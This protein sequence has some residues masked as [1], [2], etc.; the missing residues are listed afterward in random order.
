M[1]IEYLEKLKK[2]HPA[3][4]LL[5]ADHAPLIISFLYSK[6]IKP[7]RRAIPWSELMSYLDDYLYPLRETY[8]E[9][10]Y[11][12]SAREY[13][14]D[15]SSD[16]K[17][18]FISKRYTGG[19]DPECDLTPATEKA[20]EWL[21]G[22]EQK[23]FIGT[24][25]RLLSMFQLLQEIVSK[26]EQ[27]PQRRILEL[28]RQKQSI[29]KEIHQV[30]NGSFSSLDETQIKERFYQL[31]ETARKLLAD[32]RQVEENFRA[33]DTETRERIATSEKTK[34]DLLDE[35]FSEQDFI[36]GSDQGKSFLA[37]W[38]FLMSPARQTELENL[39]DTVF[40]LQAIQALEPD[41]FLQG[42]KFYLL[43]AGEKVYKTNNRL[44]EQLRRY[45]DE[46]TFLENK[47]IM[48]LIKSVEKQ[49]IECKESIPQERDFV[50]L[51]DVK[52][53]LDLA[54]SRGLYKPA[55]KPL[56]EEIPLPA[57][58][59]DIE[60]SAL[61]RQNYVDAEKLKAR[62]RKLLQTQE[63]V[64]LRQVTE[65]FP[66][67]KGLAELVVYLNLAEQDEKA[68][69]FDE[70]YEDLYLTTPAGKPKHIHMPKVI[71]TR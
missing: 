18:P 14:E 55:K 6:F 12:K 68:I 67:R 53:N 7:N 66:I 40:R 4:R 61:Y 9:D 49:A 33:L 39:L 45:L 35:I 54:L 56:I 11:P 5:S 24:E 44:I 30:R 21:R 26:T 52:P 10:K 57:E 2:L 58:D 46:Q 63:Q 3:W 17:V 47:R 48:A 23:R 37:F 15:W 13:L 50:F 32:F 29:E 38:K 25:S 59:A 41:N 28:E 20:I 8:G 70:E 27:D 31:E 71:F 60:V 19:D 69:I 62:I 65:R 34:G 1:N 51:D 42:I 64:S 43:E 36:R 16:A 22:L